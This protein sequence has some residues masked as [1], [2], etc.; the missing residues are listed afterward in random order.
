M[1]S[2][3]IH[4]GIDVWDGS[5]GVHIGKYRSIGKYFSWV[6]GHPSLEGGQQVQ[7]SIVQAFMTLPSRISM[8]MVE[9]GLH[10]SMAHS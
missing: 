9:G 5:W 7:Q 1:S 10:P 8:Y 4:L 3:T 6:L 2:S